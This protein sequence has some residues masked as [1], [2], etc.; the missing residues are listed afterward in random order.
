MHSNSSSGD[1]NSSRV[2]HLV[3]MSPS[4]EG[5]V[6]WGGETLINSVGRVEFQDKEGIRRV[7]EI[8]ARTNF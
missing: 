3:I 5:E 6:L 1:I 2:P 4:E 8:G 7:R